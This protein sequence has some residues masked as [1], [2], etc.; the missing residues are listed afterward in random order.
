MDV[1]REMGTKSHEILC[2]RA[3]DSRFYFKYNSKPS[4]GIKHDLI[5]TL[6]SY[7]GLRCRERVVM[8]P[9]WMRNAY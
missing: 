4:E 7:F 3:E 2:E 1:V 8:G 5:F 9:G 6:K